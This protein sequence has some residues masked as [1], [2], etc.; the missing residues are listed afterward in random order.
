LSSGEQSVQE[1]TLAG[2]AYMVA[3]F[4]ACSTLTS[5]YSAIPAMLISVLMA[6][7]LFDS[8]HLA[9]ST[10]IFLDI[11]AIVLPVALVWYFL[12]KRR[13]LLA[14]RIGIGMGIIGIIF[15]LIFPSGIDNL[16]FSQNN[17]AS[18]SND[19]TFFLNYKLNELG[20][21]I[22]SNLVSNSSGSAVAVKLDFSDG[23]LPKRY[24]V[25]TSLGTR[26]MVRLDPTHVALFLQLPHASM[27]HILVWNVK[28]GEIHERAHARMAQNCAGGYAVASPDTRFVIVAMRS[29]LGEGY[30][31][32]VIDLQQGRMT[33]V[34]PH[35]AVVPLFADIETMQASWRGNRAF[36]SGLWDSDG[37]NINLTPPGASMLHIPTAGRKLP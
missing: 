26:P 3:I 23:R 10:H 16:N 17:Q 21:H 9:S 22:E 1:T 12:A 30:D 29:A 11:I 33:M 28:T 8:S 20:W 5:I 31:F 37:L 4:L 32:W 35:V 27:A 2:V 34:M 14:G 6:F 7:I 18:N 13:W 25:T 24:S 15:F 36:I 19:G